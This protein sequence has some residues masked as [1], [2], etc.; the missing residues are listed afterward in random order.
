MSKPYFEIKVVKTKKPKIKKEGNWVNGENL[1]KIKF[2]CLCSYVYMNVKRFGELR[3]VA[4][5]KYGSI[6]TI[7]NL[8]QMKTTSG[9]SVREFTLKAIIE[10][11][12]V[13]ILKG[14]IILFEEE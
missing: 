6:Y 13:H 5:G 4:D 12:N 10:N 11:Y 8:R 3:I 2:P 7:F 14:K 1:D 9:W